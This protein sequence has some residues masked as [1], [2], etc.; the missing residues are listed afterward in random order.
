MR[1]RLM[2]LLLML[3]M[4]F[5]FVVPMHAVG[6]TYEPEIAGVTSLVE[7]DGFV[8]EITESVDEYY[9]TT[10]IF[11]RSFVPF[12]YETDYEFANALLLAL[13][14]S[15]EIIDMMC[16]E[17][18]ATVATT[19]F[20]TTTVSYTAADENG[21]YRYVTS[22]Y[23]HQR[24]AND[25]ATR[26]A[27]IAEGIGLLRG[28]DENI[29]QFQKDFGTLRIHHG[30]FRIGNTRT[31]RFASSGEWL[32]MPF[33]RQHGSLGSMSNDTSVDRFSMSGTIRYS[34][35]SNPTIG[36]SSTFHR[37]GQILDKRTAGDARDGAAMTFELPASDVTIFGSY[38]AHDFRA[39]FTFIG[40][41]R[42]SGNENYPLNSSAT[43]VHQTLSFFPSV[44]ISASGF[45]IGI[46]FSSGFAVSRTNDLAIRR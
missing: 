44:S 33:N 13:G 15:P 31:Y 40:E 17:V 22:S 42:G 19:T 3:V 32:V 4:V 41:V 8:F 34:R 30:A 38:R 18:L 23:A 21:E 43:Y 16:S 20:A 37:E 39:F 25:T 6:A 7:V 5:G 24:V 14:F 28:S 27:R 45:S 35:T 9:H 46:G 26:E 36:I 11:E 1:K 29:E 2:A 12:S 10:R